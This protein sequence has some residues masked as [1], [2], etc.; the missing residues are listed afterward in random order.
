MT[1]VGSFGDI[2]RPHSHTLF[3]VCCDLLLS[4][5]LLPLLDEGKQSLLLP[6]STP[7]LR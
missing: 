6:G 2:D 3:L 5:L 4:V 1:I 7:L